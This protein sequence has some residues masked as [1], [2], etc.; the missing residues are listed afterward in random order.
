MVYWSVNRATAVM[1]VERARWRRYECR[2]QSHGGASGGF[3]K[4]GRAANGNGDNCFE[5]IGNKSS[6]NKAWGVKLCSQ[7]YSF[8]FVN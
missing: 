2:R 1:R 6:T 5:I 7:M 4:Y 3:E 8:H